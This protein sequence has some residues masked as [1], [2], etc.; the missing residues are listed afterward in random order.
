[1]VIII[2]AIPE[3]SSPSMSQTEALVSM[4]CVEKNNN[5]I[6]VAVTVLTPGEE[7]K[8]NN[9]RNKKWNYCILIEDKRLENTKV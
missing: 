7:R 9:I 8:V 1:M 2:I 3:I 6:E 5:D 4:M